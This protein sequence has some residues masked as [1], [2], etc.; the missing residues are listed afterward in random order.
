MRLLSVARGPVSGRSGRGPK[1]RG[2]AAAVELAFLAPFLVA[3][4][5]GMFEIGRAL[6]VKQTLSAAARKGCRTGILH[7]YGNADIINDV[8]NVMQDNGFDVTLFNP[9]AIGAITI[10]VTDPKGNAL[11]DSLDAPEGSTVSVQVSIP[12]SSVKWVSAVFLT[13]SMVE[14]DA[15]VMMK[16]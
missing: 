14:S 8:N 12:I 4:I 13:T 7:Q 9:P 3:I 5:L 6:M 11:A 2:G 16:Q 15:V 10:T 1:R